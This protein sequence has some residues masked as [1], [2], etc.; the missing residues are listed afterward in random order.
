MA[1]AIEAPRWWAHLSGHIQRCSNP[2]RVAPPLPKTAQLLVTT[3][4]SS[5]VIS[6]AMQWVLQYLAFTLQLGVLVSCG[7]RNKLPQLGWLQATEIYSHSSGRQKFKIEVSARLCSLSLKALGEGL[8]H[9][10]L[11]GSGVSGNPLR[12]FSLQTHHSNLHLHCHRHRMMFSPSSS[13]SEG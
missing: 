2:W 1:H 10:F 12:F 4:D 7:C 13:F 5:T 8:P 3:W 11:L 6:P 9:A